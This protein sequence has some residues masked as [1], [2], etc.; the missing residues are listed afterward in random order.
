M[1]S[2]GVAWVVYLRKPALAAALARDP[3]GRLLHRFWFSD[4]GL[5]WLYDRL[6]VRPFVWFARVNKGDVIDSFYD[7]L[8]AWPPCCYRALSLTETGSLRW[9]AAWIAG[10]AVDLVAMV[11]FL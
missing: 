3:A 11:V 6:F 5:D 9:Y 4:W 8:A 2:S 1:R 7:G 10:G